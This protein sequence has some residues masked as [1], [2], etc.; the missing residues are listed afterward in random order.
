M[1]KKYN[2]IYADPPWSYQNG[3]VPQGGVNAQYKTMKLQDIKDLPIDE[4]S[5]DISVLF[6]WATFPQ[7][8]EALE[9]IK[10]WGFTYKTLGFSWIKTNKNNGEPFFGIGYYAKSNCEVCLMATKGKAH[11]LVKSNKVSSVLIHKR[12]KHSKKPDIVAEKIVELFGDIPRIEL[13]ARDKK[14]GW[15]VFGN[16]VESDIKLTKK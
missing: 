10:A 7:L 16:E 3:G 11:S 2:I 1:S 6:M 8:Q 4:I 9:V 15:D 14:E 12:T 13:F 5:E